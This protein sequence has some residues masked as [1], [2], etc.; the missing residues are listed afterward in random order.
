MDI[1]K[2]CLKKWGKTAMLF[3]FFEEMSELMDAVSKRMNDRCDNDKVAEEIA[4]VTLMIGQIC[5]VFNIPIDLV[6]YYD[7]LKMKRLEEM[8]WK[9]E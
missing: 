1:F 6:E 8:F 3:K 2:K 9:G 7:E 5:T 4:D